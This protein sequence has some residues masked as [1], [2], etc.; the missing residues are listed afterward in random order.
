M[1]NRVS[2]MS[3]LKIYRVT[4]GLIAMTAVTPAFAQTVPSGSSLPG[5]GSRS[6]AGTLPEIMPCDTKDKIVR[7]QAPSGTGT[8]PAI[9]VPP[10]PG[11]PAD[12]KMAVPTRPDTVTAL[13][14]CTLPADPNT[15]PPDAKGNVKQGVK[16]ERSH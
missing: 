8:D 3:H 13:P 6:G 11:E 2:I 10:V 1:P 4:L 12:R 9:T 7:A 16:K 5:T 15:R 14:N